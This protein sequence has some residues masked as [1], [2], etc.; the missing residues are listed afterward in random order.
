MKNGFYATDML[1]EL[2]NPNLRIKFLLKIE[3]VT[4][5]ALKNVTY[6]MD[7]IDRQSI[8]NENIKK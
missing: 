7:A 1:Q 6:E 4:D 2:Y 3:D 5:K 8:I